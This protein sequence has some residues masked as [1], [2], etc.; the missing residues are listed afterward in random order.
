LI[1]TNLTPSGYFAR[2][3][4]A[5]GIVHTLNWIEPR[6]DETVCGLDLSGMRPVEDVDTTCQ[7]CL[8]A[9][10][11]RSMEAVRSAN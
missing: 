7:A 3:T 9:V 11:L 2:A 8:L 4:S 5:D 1:E 10:L 6:I